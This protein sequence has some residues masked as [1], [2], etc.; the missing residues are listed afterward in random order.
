[1]KKHKIYF[2]ALLILCTSALLLSC[3]KK[4]ECDLCGEM[5]ICEERDF[6]DEKILICENCLDDFKEDDYDLQTDQEKNTSFFGLNDEDKALRRPINNFFD[7]TIKGNINKLKDLAPSAF[8]ENLELKNDVKITDIKS[9]LEK[10]F[11]DQ[12]QILEKEYG[13][14]LKVEFVILDKEELDEYDLDDLKDALKESYGISEKS[15][16]KAFEVEVE[17]TIKGDRDEDTD[18]QDMTIVKIDGK[19]YISTI[20]SML[21][22]Y[23]N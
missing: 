11:E 8:W 10:E 3:A 22:Y 23:A 16:S 15:V 7:F 4:E 20:F 14:N 13:K 18:E 1:M 6:W 5:G 12:L 2:T 19:W 17:A 9:S 21:S